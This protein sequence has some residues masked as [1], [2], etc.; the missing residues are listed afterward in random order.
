M[1]ATSNRPPQHL[2]VYFVIVLLVIGSGG[3]LL[4]LVS[5]MYSIA[6][7]CNTNYML[8]VSLSTQCII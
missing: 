7:T 3:G 4:C 1:V 8:S 5:C 2:Y 6:L